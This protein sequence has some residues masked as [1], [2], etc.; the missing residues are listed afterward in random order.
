MYTS[1]FVIFRSRVETS[2]V[3]DL[4]VQLEGK[5]LR[6]LSSVCWKKFYF[7]DVL[8]SGNSDTIVLIAILSLLFFSQV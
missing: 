3:R 1:E 8:D 2:Q 6:N 4:P 7:F 5:H